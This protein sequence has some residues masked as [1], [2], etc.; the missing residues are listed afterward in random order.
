MKRIQ[1]FFLICSVLLMLSGCFANS[2]QTI[3]SAPP[4]ATQPATTATTLPATIPVPDS[5][6]SQQF[7]YPL[8]AI[9]LPS[10]K[11]TQLA[12]DGKGLFEYIY[13]TIDVS[14]KD[15]DINRQ[16]II[17][18]LN[19]TDFTGSAAESVYH[20]A[21]SAYDGQENWEAYK[22]SVRYSV[23][24]IDQNILSLYAT[25]IYYDGAPQSGTVA[26]SMNYDLLNGNCLA[27]R[28][29]LIPDF[30]S[31]T[32]C[33]L[34]IDGFDS[35]ITED[36]YSDYAYVIYD[37]FSTNI[38]VENWYLSTAGLC[39]FFNP[40][41]VAPYSEDI[42]VS[43]I[44][45]SELTGILRDEYFPAEIPAYNGIPTLRRMDN[46]GSSAFESVAELILAE[47]AQFYCLTTDG[48]VT[49]IR[50]FSGTWVSS[51]DFVPEAT[52]FAAQALTETTAL[53]ISCEEEM[54]SN[55]CIQYT[56]AGQVYSKP[57]TEIIS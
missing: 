37:L 52:I 46:I 13:Q 55:I 39:F 56:S 33:E 16:V 31:A 43:T 18:F 41:E 5:T 32:I 20:A 19:K 11:D 29:V 34:I 23:P 22:Y 53:F 26:Q 25:S 4:V 36:F 28:N 14:T 6:L 24:R 27:L 49:D 12:A 42:P 10:Y 1:V 35:A 47:D 50:L 54:L 48:T 45:Y 2:L 40:G 17:D 30:D 51:T 15:P 57:I 7:P 8:S 44:P 21:Q 38:P 3:P 9:S